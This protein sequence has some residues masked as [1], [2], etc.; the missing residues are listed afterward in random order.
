MVK[1][2]M[3]GTDPATWDPTLDGVLAEPE[4]HTVLYAVVAQ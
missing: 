3:D 4:N 2:S 1:L